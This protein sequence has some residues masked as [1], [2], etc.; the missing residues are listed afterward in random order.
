MTSEEGEKWKEMHGQ[1]CVVELHLR[2]CVRE[3]MKRLPDIKKDDPLTPMLWNYDLW[4]TRAPDNG[5]AE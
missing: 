5:T 1:M 2:H 3:L 4:P